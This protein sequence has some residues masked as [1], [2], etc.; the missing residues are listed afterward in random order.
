MNVINVAQMAKAEFDSIYSLFF[1]A[2]SELG[3]LD[4]SGNPILETVKIIEVGHKRSKKVMTAPSEKGEDIASHVVIPPRGFSLNCIVPTED[5]AELERYFLTS[6]LISLTTTITTYDN[7]II[8]DLPIGEG[9]DG[10]MGSIAVQMSL[11]EV[12][13]VESTFVKGKAVVSTKGKKAKRKSVGKVASSAVSSK[14]AGGTALQATASGIG[15]IASG[16]GG[17]FK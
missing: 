1:G 13:L 15:K 11:E 12:K 10:M 6:E 14:T 7:L 3:F 17:L 2:S 5:V 4:S 8:S 16:I 9:K